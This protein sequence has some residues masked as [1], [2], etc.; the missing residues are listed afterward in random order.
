[1]SSNLTEVQALENGRKIVQHLR[2]VRQDALAR[3][4]V[5]NSLAGESLEF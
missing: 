2:N 1:M 5:L 4:A 3:D